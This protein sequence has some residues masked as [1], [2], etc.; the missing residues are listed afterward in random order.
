MA[1]IINFQDSKK[2]IWLLDRITA[3]HI[4]EMADKVENGHRWYFE[5]CPICGGQYL[6]KFGHRCED[7]LRIKCEPKYSTLKEELYPKVVELA[8]EEE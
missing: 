7:T 4:C 8:D 1:E 5:E 3:V 2:S 6:E